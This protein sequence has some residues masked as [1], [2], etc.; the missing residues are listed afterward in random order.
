M[1]GVALRCPHCGTTQSGPGECGACHEATVQYFCAN[2]SPGRWLDEPSCT[3]CGARFGEARPAPRV[4]PTRP[5]A[6]PPSL[7]A[8]PAAGP[9]TARPPIRTAPR[10][11]E[12]SF[13]PRMAPPAPP[14]RSPWL[15]RAPYPAEPRPRDADISGEDEAIRR[16]WAD[17]VRSRMRSGFGAEAREPRSPLPGCRRVALVGMIFIVTLIA[18]ALFSAGPILE[19]LLQI[20]L[21]Q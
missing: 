9:R 16:R 21:S 14:T 15:R 2:H 5:S 6:P 18:M 20:L 10:R 19:L 3:L 12:A 7:S 13:D 17:V 8:P 11:S 1:N 4:P